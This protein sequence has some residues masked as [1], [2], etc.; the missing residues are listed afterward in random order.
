MTT[1]TA[2][3]VETPELYERVVRPYVQAI[4]PARLQWVYNILERKV[5]E[6]R[7]L[8]ACPRLGMPW[9]GC[10]AASGAVVNG[11]RSHLFQPQPTLKPHLHRSSS[12]SL[13]PHSSTSVS[14]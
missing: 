14:F 6:Q 5:L 8:A 9:L 2:Q 3:V 12:S 1:L 13:S 7:S 4:P 10:L 11:H